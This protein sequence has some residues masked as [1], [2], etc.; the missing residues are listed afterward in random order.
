M[1]GE[2]S[3][4]LS[5]KVFQGQCHLIEKG[6]RQG[7]PAGYGLRR[8]RL[9]Q[10]GR[11]LGILAP[12]EQKGLQTDRV[13]LGPGP[14][15]ERRQIER[16]FRLFVEQGLHEQ[17]IAEK[18]NTEGVPAD[19]GQSWSKGR[20]R[21]ILTNEKYIGHNVYNRTSFKLKA[22]RVSNPPDMWVRKDNAWPAIV[23]PQL[24]FAAR[25]ILVERARRY[26]DE[27]LLSRLRQLRDRHGYVSAILID[28]SEILP[29][30]AVYSARFGGLIRAYALIGYTP[31]RDYRYIEIN[32]RLRAIHPEVVREIVTQMRRYSGDVVHHESTDLIS[33]TSVHPTSPLPRAWIRRTRGSVTITFCQ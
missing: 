23:E 32:R 20:I 19:L 33:I 21:Q 22:K 30:S 24:F 7:G 9:D 10:N 14:P 28:E 15:E 5:A 31:K 27:D 12:G 11:E 13:V 29:S 2:Y 16:I 3:R 26:S 1:A 25:G 18:L 6:Y 4:E 17:E 8:M